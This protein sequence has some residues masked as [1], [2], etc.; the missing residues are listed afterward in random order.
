MGVWYIDL[1]NK[2]PEGAEIL[3]T[4]RLL[5]NPNYLNK[6]DSHKFKLSKQMKW[7]KPKKWGGYDT[8]N[9]TFF[10]IT[11]DFKTFVTEKDEKWAESYEDYMS[12]N[13]NKFYQFGCKQI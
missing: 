12:Q 1:E 8:E 10:L 11:K 7:E 5:V 13:K 6:Q 9:L 3:V 2:L 4:P